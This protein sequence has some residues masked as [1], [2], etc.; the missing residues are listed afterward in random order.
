MSNK[1]FCETEACKA[2]IDD[3]SHSSKP[4]FEWGDPMKVHTQTD[5]KGPS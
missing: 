4:V 2:I 5:L 1:Q 3:G